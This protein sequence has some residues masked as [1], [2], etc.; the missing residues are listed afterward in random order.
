V[1]GS[2]VEMWEYRS[3]EEMERVN[4]TV[5]KHKEMK[6]IDTEFKKMIDHTTFT[7]SI[8]DTVE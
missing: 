8:W 5:M 2:H 6:E 4:A 3:M 7:Q 1:A